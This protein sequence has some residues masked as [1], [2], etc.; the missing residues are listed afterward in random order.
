MNQ[1]QFYPTISF[2]R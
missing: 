1:M 2:G